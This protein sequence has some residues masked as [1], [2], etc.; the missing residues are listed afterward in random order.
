MRLVVSAGV[1]LALCGC[2]A[3]PFRTAVQSFASTTVAASDQ[4]EVM[5]SKHRGRRTEEIRANL[6]EERARLVPDPDT[7]QPLAT[8]DYKPS[9]CRVLVN[10]QE[11]VPQAFDAPAV[12]EL[13]AALANY[14][15]NLGVLAGAATEDSAAFREAA[16]GLTTSFGTLTN[17]ISNS[18]LPLTIDIEENDLGAVATIIGEIGVLYFEYQRVAMMREIIKE[19]DPAVQDATEILADAAGVWAKSENEAFLSKFRRETEKLDDL[20]RKENEGSKVTDAAFSVQQVSVLNAHATYTTDVL[21]VAQS[22]SAFVELGNAHAELA[23]A[24]R[25]GG[26]REDVISALQ[27]IAAAAAAIREPVATLF[28]GDDAGEPSDET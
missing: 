2:A 26:S 24:A 23:A 6:A 20:V 22:Q 25:A 27:R 11:P 1:A 18:R 8:P 14:A 3:E 9:A 13:R 28:N 5:Q 7:C 12:V 16:A 17:T 10:G 19:T 4:L 21:P 15:T